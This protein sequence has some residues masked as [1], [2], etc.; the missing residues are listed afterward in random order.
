MIELTIEQRRAVG[1]QTEDPP[2]AVDPDTRTTY[3]LIR[4]ELYQRVQSLFADEQEQE[5]LR[6]MYPHV[7]QVFGKAGW[8]DPA[9][10]IY[11]E[12][13]PRRQP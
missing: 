8:D 9:M 13:D 4:E 11:D 3:V 12:L 2:R 6:N 10:D 7:M 1:K 5:F